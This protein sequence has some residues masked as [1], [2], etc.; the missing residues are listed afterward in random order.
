MLGGGCRAGARAWVSELNEL[1]MASQHSVR[2]RLL[3][4]PL[5]LGGVCCVQH[6]AWIV[7]PHT[8]AA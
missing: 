1:C 5:L 7:L 6:P 3:P 2:A 4:P 8:P